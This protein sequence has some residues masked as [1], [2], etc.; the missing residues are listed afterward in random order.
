MQ[1]PIHSQCQMRE[2][3]TGALHFTS[4]NFLIIFLEGQGRY[5]SGTTKMAHT[6]NYSLASYPWFAGSYR[7]A[8]RASGAKLTLTILK[9]VLRQLKLFC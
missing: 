9:K 6:W 4:K 2:L 8:E 3:S 5:T 1:E 7:A